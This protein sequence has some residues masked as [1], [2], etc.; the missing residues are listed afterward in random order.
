M[1][2]ENTQYIEGDRGLLP[3]FVM[4][5]LKK[6]RTDVQGFI[7]RADRFLSCQ[8]QD[9][10][11]IDDV[12]IVEPIQVQQILQLQSVA[13]C[14]RYDSISGTHDIVSRRADI[15]RRNDQLL[16]GIDGVRRR[17]TVCFGDHF[18]AAAEELCDPVQRVAGSDGILDR[19]HGKPLFC[20]S[21]VHNM[22]KEL[23]C[24]TPAVSFAKSRQKSLQK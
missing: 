14:D 20:I 3:P 12:R 9:L 10:T 23:S 4:S 13:V 6:P 11:G 2:A 17:Q 21:I 8:P 19:F 18:D 15:A 22:R 16:T 24:E 7:A 5:R 1:K